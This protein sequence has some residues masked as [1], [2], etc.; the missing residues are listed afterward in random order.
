MDEQFDEWL[1]RLGEEI[2]EVQLVAVESCWA[3]ARASA[4]PNLAVPRVAR[5]GRCAL[6]LTWGDRD[7][8]LVVLVDEKGAVEW[9]QTRRLPDGPVRAVLT[10]GRGVPTAEIRRAVRGPIVR[11]SRAA[12][13]R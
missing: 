2:S 1:A 13:A 10:S 3:V 6:R 8:T 5:S 11:R 4:K 12:E 9:H 7:E